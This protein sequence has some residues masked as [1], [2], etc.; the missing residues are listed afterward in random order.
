[1]ANFIVQKFINF[2]QNIKELFT[3]GKEA[4]INLIDTIAAER[5]EDSVVK[6][7]VSSSF[8]RHYTAISHAL[9]DLW[10]KKPES[11]QQK[12]SKGTVPETQ[13]QAGC[14]ELTHI[15]TECCPLPVERPFSLFGM[16]CTSTERMFAKRLADR[17]MV[18]VP[19]KV[20]GAPVTIGHQYSIV[21]CLPEEAEGY[22]STWVYPL[23]TRRVK[24]TEFGPEVGMEQLHSLLKQKKF[25]DKLCV[26]VG[27]AAYSASS[28]VNKAQEMDNAINIFRLRGNRVL[29]KPLPETEQPQR[30]GRPP[31]YGEALRLQDPTP[32]DEKQ[33]LHTETKK[34]LTIEVEIERWKNVLM[35]GKEQ[36]T[37]VDVM[38]VRVRNEQGLAVYSKPLWLT[39]VGK[40]RL[41][42]T[43]AQIY[44]AYTQRYNIEHY[45]RFSKKN[46]L[47]DKLQTPDVEQE[48]N[49]WS[50]S[51]VAY[52]MLYLTCP[53][54]EHIPYP[55]EKQHK[56]QGCGVKNSPSQAQRGYE[57]IIRQIG[58]EAS[59]PKPRGKSLG[60]RKGQKIRRRSKQPVI[61]KTKKSRKIA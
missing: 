58:V 27:D 13:R 23:S 33:I 45:F 49:W 40:R 10:R 59:L 16:D 4:L 50:L 42:L 17:T 55:W 48:E 21:V 39:I 26:N 32:A 19:N 53:L 8:K 36:C 3:Y 52:T 41:E 51:L 31:K 18:H 24:S 57:R 2:R 43:L 35:R 34:G 38:R 56:K 29:Y 6:M 9:S 37:P 11:A 5:H 61:K 30:R 60:R 28:C 54:S 20:A 1:M 25:H 44:D 12:K 7:S 15:L 47:M 22:S 46:L 14:L